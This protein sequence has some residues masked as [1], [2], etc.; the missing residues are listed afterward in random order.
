MQFSYEEDLEDHLRYTETREGSFVELA[1]G[2]ARIWGESKG[3]ATLCRLCAKGVEQPVS[4][5]VRNR[6]QQRFG[7]TAVPVEG[8]G[9]VATP[10]AHRRKGYMSRL[11]RKAIE[12]ASKRVDALFLFGV[13]G[14]YPSYGFAP[15]MVHSELVLPVH[16]GERARLM[17]GTELRPMIGTD[18]E[19][20][21]G[22]FNQAHATRPCSVAREARFFAGPRGAEDWHAGEVGKVLRKDG[23]FLGYVIHTVDSFGQRHPLSVTELVGRD[24]DATEALIHEVVRVAI[25]R[26]MEKVTFHDTPDSLT[27]LVLR[28]LDAQVRLTYPFDGD[29]MGLICNRRHLLVSLAGELERRAGRAEPD[30]LEALIAGEMY[31]ENRMLLQLITGFFSFKDAEQM[32]HALP[33]GYEPVVKK[34]FPGGGTPELPLPYTHRLDRY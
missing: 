34:W 14:L 12:R 1:P 20:V 24:F 25:N 26:R 10:P 15:C 23:T 31:P 19:H 3:P 33:S 7:Q 30:A 13:R 22:L 21:C 6:F 11:I 27:G 8:Y 9:G 4:Y 2:L 5:L 17:N 32:G 18:K 16:A 28:R 29:G